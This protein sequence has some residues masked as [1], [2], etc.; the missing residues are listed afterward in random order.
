[1]GLRGE[2]GLYTQTK[3]LDHL[4]SLKEHGGGGKLQLVWGGRNEVK[5]NSRKQKFYRE[6]LS[7][8]HLVFSRVK[9]NFILIRLKLTVYFKMVT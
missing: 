7:C 8:I 3:R 2:W 6:V 4:I 9:I 1:M 5:S